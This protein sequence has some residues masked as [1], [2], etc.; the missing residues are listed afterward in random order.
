M[1]SPMSRL[2][3]SGGETV[4]IDVVPKVQQ[5]AINKIAG[6]FS[7]A[8][9]TALGKG[10]AATPA[11]ASG[12]AA[13]STG[14]MMGGGPMAAAITSIKMFV[15]AA[16]PAVVDQFNMAIKDTVAV[17]GHALTPVLQALTPGLRLFGDLLAS[18]MP[19]WE[20]MEAITG[21]LNQYFHDMRKAIE[22]I[23]PILKGALLLAI[24]GVGE[25]LE[26]LAKGIVQLTNWMTDLIHKAEIGQV[27][28]LWDEG[29]RG[30]TTKT[31]DGRT[32]AEVVKEAKAKGYTREKFIEQAIGVQRARIEGESH[33]KSS[34]GA[35][36]HGASSTSVAGLGSNLQM[37]A[38]GMGISPEKQT[39][40]N[41]KMTAEAAQEMLQ[42][43][44][45]KGVPFVPNFQQGG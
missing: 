3:S 4:L 8:I 5:S 19:S 2:S 23:I 16:N 26:I 38:F 17:V 43:L 24:Q 6:Q 22:P 11:I 14:G 35:S 25:A 37:A 7:N 27:G 13:G 30:G 21:P 20:E 39:A 44:R 9:G 29:E 12:I 33:F 41:T 1:S 42:E 10:I 31:G 40:Q 15:D 32:V 36:G 34:T 18:I 45:K 28:Q